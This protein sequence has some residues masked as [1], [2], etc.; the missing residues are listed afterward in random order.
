MTTAT[1]AWLIGQAVFITEVI[2]LQ[3]Q[4]FMHVLPN[5]RSWSLVVYQKSRNSEVFCVWGLSSGRKCEY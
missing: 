5:S 1:H 2:T 3:R 4:T